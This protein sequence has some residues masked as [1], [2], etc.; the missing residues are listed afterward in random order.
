[1]RGV[2]RR[3]KK[4]WIRYSF[5]GKLVRKSIGYSK[6]EAEQALAAVRGD[7][8]RG[9]YRLRGRDERRTFGE[10]AG[11]YL[12]VKAEKRSLKRDRVSFRQLLPEFQHRDLREISPQDVEAYARKRKKSVTGAAVNRELALLRHV[13]N[14]AIARGYLET[15]PARGVRRF[16]EAPP[17]YKY[18]FS[19]AE[20]HRLIAAA[21][22]HLRPILWLAFGTGLRKG[23]VLGLRWRDVDL[24]RGVITLWMQKTGAPLEIPV[25]P[26]LGEMLERMRAAAGGSDYV[27]P[28]QGP[29]SR[30]GDVKTAFRTALR[31]SGLA[32]RGYR[33]HDIRRTFATMLYNRGVSLVKIQRLLGHRSVTTTERYLGVKFE[34]TRQAVLLLD[35]ALAPAA[36]CGCTVAAQSLPGAPAIR[37]I[38]GG[39]DPK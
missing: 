25:L 11:E 24:E 15:N 18:L 29:G 12:E 4:W 35:S 13:L 27:F 19:E 28:G 23:D 14:I 1:M 38:S 2:Y 33:F 37:L 22:A 3:G 16:Q 10:M 6:G 17:R 34:E 39:S 31:V 8:I 9:E 32:G 30:L 36:D 20:M 26:M 5:G 21:A 7:I